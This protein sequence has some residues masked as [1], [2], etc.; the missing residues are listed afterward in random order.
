MSRSIDKIQDIFLSLIVVIHLNRMALDSDTF[1]S[2]Q[3]HVI[4]DLV[5]HLPLSKSLGKFYQPVRKR[6][7]AMVDM[8]DNTEIPNIL[9]IFY[10]LD[11]ESVTSSSSSRPV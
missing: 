9:H 2:F 8:C 11:D 5:L 6:T 3:V 10:L 1:L 7:L 4:Q